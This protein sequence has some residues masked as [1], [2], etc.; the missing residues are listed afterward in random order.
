MST[1]VLDI[2]NP[3]REQHTPHSLAVWMFAF[4]EALIAEAPEARAH[5]T[6]MTRRVLVSEVVDNHDTWTLSRSTVRRH[7]RKAYQFGILQPDGSWSLPFSEGVVYMLDP[8]ET[9]HR[10]LAGRASR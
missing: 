1:R 2:L 5:L 7:L 10:V 8:V 3:K 4:T 6:P 9:A